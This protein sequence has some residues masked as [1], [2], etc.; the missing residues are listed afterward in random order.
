MKKPEL[1]I[2][3]GDVMGRFKI[4]EGKEVGDKLKQAESLWIDSG[5]KIIT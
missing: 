4:P 5:F 3:A 1:P 2:I